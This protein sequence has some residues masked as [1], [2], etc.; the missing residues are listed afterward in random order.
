MK[1]RKTPMLLLLTFCCLVTLLL[2]NLQAMETQEQLLV[3]LEAEIHAST[4]LSDDAKD[5]V[6]GILLPKITNPVLITEIKAQNA[7]NVS[8]VAIKEIDGDWK[9]E[10]GDIP[11]HEQLMANT[12]ANELSTMVAELPQITEC[13]VMDNQGANVGQYNETSDYW[14]GDE[15][16]WQNSFNNGKGG[17]D[18]GDKEIDES[19]AMAQQQ[20]SLPIVDG[21]GTV[22]GAITFGLDVSSMR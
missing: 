7:K 9:A 18:V 17:V 16:K 15:A 3:R 2:S 10:E 22:V 20:I 19:T 13:F 4:N 14:Q 1:G 21:D 11:L 8:L 5:M 6:T 12:T